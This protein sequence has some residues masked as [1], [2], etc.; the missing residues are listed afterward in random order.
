MT[1]TEI[2]ILR[3]VAW[4]NSIST[5]SVARSMG[6]SAEYITTIMQGLMEDGYLE[7]AKDCGY[8]I[9]HKAT[10]AI[11]PYTGCDGGGRV[12]VSSFSYHRAHSPAKAKQV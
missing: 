8:V 11:R 5:T 3:I 7:N 1:G 2:Q 4:Q 10:K 9:T 6:V 12:A